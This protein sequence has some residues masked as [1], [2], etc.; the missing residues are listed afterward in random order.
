M[1]NY[2]CIVD[3]ISRQR[4][5]ARLWCVCVYVYVMCMVYVFLYI[6]LNHVYTS[7]RCVSLL[8]CDT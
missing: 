4:G 2:Y 8:P 1:Y 5:I 6:S 7:V 3:V